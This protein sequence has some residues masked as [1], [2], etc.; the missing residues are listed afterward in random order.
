M[1]KMG[2]KILT[3]Q[4]LEE[5]VKKKKMLPAIPFLEGSSQFSHL[6]RVHLEDIQ[7]RG[8]QDICTL[9]ILAPR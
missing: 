6:P 9:D 3:K 5:G 2:K 1:R 7:D 8:K 4:T